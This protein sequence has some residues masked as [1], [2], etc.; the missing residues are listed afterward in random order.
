MPAA[1]P[2]AYPRL[3]VAATQTESIEERVSEQRRALPDAPGVYIFRDAGRKVL[4]VGKARSIRK[5]VGG[6]FSKPGARG[7]GDMVSLI[8]DIDFIATETEA[9]ALLAE[10]EF[11]T[12]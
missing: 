2:A 1:R 9:E 6:H 8:A 3:G 12:R 10:Q 5:R 4:Y 7:A 11:I